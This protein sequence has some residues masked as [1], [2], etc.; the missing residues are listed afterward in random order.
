MIEYRYISVIFIFLFASCK[1]YQ[2]SQKSL[3]H[4]EQA[5]SVE[6][7]ID[8]GLN[9][10]A[11]AEMIGPWYS[12]EN[13]TTPNLFSDGEKLYLS[14][15]VL[16]GS[17]A[18][19]YYSVY[20][21]KQWEAPRL[22]SQGNDWFVN[23]ADFPQFAVYENKMIATFLQKSDEG[24]YTYDI[25][26]TLK[27]GENT[28]TNPKKLHRDDT[29][30]EHG[31]VSIA[32]GKEG[33]LVSWLD[34]R[35]T[36]IKENSPSQAQ[37]NEHF[38]HGTGA[39]TLRSTMVHFN[40]SLGEESLVDTRVCDCCQTAVIL[41]QN[42]QA[43]LAYRGRSDTEVRDILLRKGSPLEGWSSSVT[44]N[45]QWLIPGCPVNGPSIDVFGDAL[46]LSWFTASKDEPR[47]EVAFSSTEKLGLTE[48]TRMDSGNAI[49]RVDVVQL[50]AESAI[51][52]WVEPMGKTD[53]I[54]AQWVDIKGKKGPLITVSE[55]SSERATG[56]P[57][58]VR[59]KDN[60]YLVTTNLKPDKSKAVIL[61]TWPISTMLLEDINEVKA[62]E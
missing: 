5:L 10:S 20:G 34:G 22:I 57:R 55:T 13:T 59:H 45:D 49:G 12:G 23:W 41:D 42:N 31:F 21:Q 17:Q 24:T 18:S 29:K 32:P 61:K 1:D 44:T 26:Y 2:N 7:S 6:K 36:V 28:W 3:N 9:T 62:N 4:S 33:F 54:R 16:E 39:M 58:M 46:A 37:N 53:Y 30:S 40:G 47:V 38:N 60:L 15:V 48:A 56:F 19:L 11:V 52:S 50:S 35:N 51:V 43:F 14:W 8:A 27:E 25:Y